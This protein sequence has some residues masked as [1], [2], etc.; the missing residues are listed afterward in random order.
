MDF[1]E[2]RCSVCGEMLI[3]MPKECPNCLSPEAK[4]LINL[5]HEI[6]RLRKGLKRIEAIAECHPTTDTPFSDLYSINTIAQETLEGRN[7]E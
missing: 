2:Y 1:G 7:E 4:E 5:R 3:E 6:T